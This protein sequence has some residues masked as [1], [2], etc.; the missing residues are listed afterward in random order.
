MK[1]LLFYAHKWWFKTASKSL[2]QVPDTDTED[3]MES[4]VVVFFHAEK[5]MKKKAKVSSTN[6]SRTSN[7]LPASS[8]QGMWLSIHSTIFHRARR[9]LNF[10]IRL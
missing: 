10:Q 9:L 6:W 4:T 7:G 3:S 8:G 5:R 2:P 1:L